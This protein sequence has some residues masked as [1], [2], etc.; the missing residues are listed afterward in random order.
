MSPKTAFETQKKDLLEGF[1]MDLVSNGI[2]EG[3]GEI[4]SDSSR[5]PMESGARA[6]AL[7]PPLRVPRR[8]RTEQARVVPARPT[9][10][11]PLPARLCKGRGPYRCGNRAVRVN[12]GRRW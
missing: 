10:L 12:G 5:K 6:T 11:C 9:P 2:A 1:L 4:E 3:V 7:A 8:V